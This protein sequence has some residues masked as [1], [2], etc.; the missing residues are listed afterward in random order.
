MM[1]LRFFCSGAVVLAPQHWLDQQKYCSETD[2]K[3]ILDLTIRFTN[4]KR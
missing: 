1:I 2:S 4:L 3:N